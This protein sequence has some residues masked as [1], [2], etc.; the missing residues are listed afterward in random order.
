MARFRPKIDGVV[1]SS[2]RAWGSDFLPPVGIA[3]DVSVSSRSSGTR[4]MQ[5]QDDRFTWKEVVL[6]IYYETT[7]QAI[8]LTGASANKIVR[9]RAAPKGG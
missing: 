2:P 1:N 8:R 9:K 3:L 7:S 5:D 6:E 4:P